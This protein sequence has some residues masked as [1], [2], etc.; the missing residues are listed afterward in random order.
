MRKLDGLTKL[1]GE[2]AGFRGVGC[3]AL[4]W[5]LNAMTEIL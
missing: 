3:S 1:L 5:Q 4:A 2:G